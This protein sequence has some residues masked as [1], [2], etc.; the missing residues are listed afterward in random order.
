MKI[1]IAVYIFLVLLFSPFIYSNNALGYKY[2]QSSHAIGMAI[3]NS[4]YWPSY[5]FST[6]PTVDGQSIDSFQ[7]SINNMLEWRANKLYTGAR[8]STDR[9]MVISSVVAC[10]NYAV[11]EKNL[12]YKFTTDILSNMDY[13]N[14]FKDIFTKTIN[15]MDGYDFADI[16]KSGSDCFDRAKS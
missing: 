11:L 9:D 2:H 7:K 14:I 4:F 3:G 5:L 16:V 15:E 6:D 8:N 12:D 1:F 13:S 10:L